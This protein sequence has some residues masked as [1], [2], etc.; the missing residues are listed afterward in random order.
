MGHCTYHGVSDQ[1]QPLKKLFFIL[2]NSA[3]PDEIPRSV[4]FHLGLHDLPESSVRG[5][6]YTKDKWRSLPSKYNRCI[7]EY[8]GSYC[9]F[10]QRRLKRICAYVLTCQSLH[11]TFVQS[12][13]TDED[14]DQI[15][16]L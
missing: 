3:Y 5:F 9:I 16:H 7:G 12:M 15:L 14:S 11:Y 4:A 8:F 1:N 13:D 10:K 2:A 6:Q